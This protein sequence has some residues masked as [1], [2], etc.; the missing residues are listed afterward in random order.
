MSNITKCLPVKLEELRKTKKCT[1][2]QYG[3][4]LNIYK[5]CIVEHLM[6]QSRCIMQVLMHR[7]RFSV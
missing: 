1:K 3:L 5:I 4:E 2:Y 6:Y 7:Q